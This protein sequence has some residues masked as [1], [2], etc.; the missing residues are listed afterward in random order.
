MPESKTA[1]SRKSLPPPSQDEVEEIIRHDLAEGHYAA[2][3]LL[4]SYRKLANQYGVTVSLIRRV[5]DQLEHEGIVSRQ[6]GR[7]VFARGTVIHAGVQGRKTLECVSVVG[8]PDLE[9]VAAGY[10]QGYTQALEGRGI[11]MRFLDNEE[12]IVS[13]ESLVAEEHSTGNHGVIM[14]RPR[15]MLMQWLDRRQIPYV[16]QAYARYD[17]RE[18]PPHHRVFVNKTQGGCMAAEHLMSLGHQCLGFVG[19]MSD[20]KDAVG[21]RVFDGFKAALNCA[22]METIPDWLLEVNSDFSAAIVGPAVEYLRQS[23][24]PTAIVAAN[25]AAAIA[26][27][28]AA[29]SVGIR[30][31]EDLSVMGFNDQREAKRTTPPLSTIAVPRRSLARTAMEL[32]LRIADGAFTVPQTRVLK[33]QLVA[34]GTTAPLASERRV[35]GQ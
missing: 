14:I 33:C 29:E 10:L 25:D 11:R 12:L 17:S 20:P 3:T 32:V 1:L 27:L 4:P 13:P 18:L 23:D 6:G 19:H 15:S 31:P 30:V 2:N 16:V 34:R 5:I 7:G 26:V 22:G 35:A 28:H 8:V 9:H 21:C 24:R